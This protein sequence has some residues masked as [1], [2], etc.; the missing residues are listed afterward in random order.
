MT[1]GYLYKLF[2]IADELTSF[3]ARKLNQELS[4]NSVGHRTEK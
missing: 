2:S 1:N 4:C 3:S